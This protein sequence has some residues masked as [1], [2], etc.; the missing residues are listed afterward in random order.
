MSQI[1]H[2][3]I[4][5]NTHKFKIKGLLSYPKRFVDKTIQKYYQRLM[6]KFEEHQI[7]QVPFS[8]HHICYILDNDICEHCWL[9]MHQGFYCQKCQIYNHNTNKESKI[10][11]LCNVQY[12]INCSNQLDIFSQ[13]KLCELCQSHQNEQFGTPSFLLSFLISLIIPCFA[14]S[15][16][17]KRMLKTIERFNYST[18]QNT[19]AISAFIMVFPFIYILSILGFL[20]L[21]IFKISIWIYEQ[22]HDSKIVKLI[23]K[24]LCVYKTK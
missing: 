6:K 15:F 9:F 2:C 4:C 5:N 3:R 16:F 8:E 20:I 22:M 24:F 19:L 14:C 13:N 18:L 1:R 17:L 7:Q 10:C 21:L 11:S 12:C 23:S